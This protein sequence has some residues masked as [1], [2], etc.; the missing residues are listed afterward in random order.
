MTKRLTSRF[1][2]EW[3]T[4][5]GGR[6]VPY[7]LV[8]GDYQ[9]SY[10]FDLLVEFEHALES[11]LPLT[12]AVAILCAIEQAGREILRFKHPGQVRFDNRQCFDEFLHNYM[13]YRPIAANRYDIFRNG[14]VHSGIPKTKRQSGIGLEVH[15][16]FLS[17]NK[18]KRVRGIHIHRSGFCDVTLAELLKEFEAGVRKMRKHEIE[19][20]WRH[21]HDEL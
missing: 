10:F 20:G 15:E 7:P 5:R 14:V 2:K 8:D 11:R 1:E 16:L 17:R 21:G 9:S 13:G 12:L 4:G 18:L 6:P 3:A 19:R